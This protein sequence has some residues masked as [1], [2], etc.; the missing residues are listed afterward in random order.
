MIWKS[1]IDKQ[2]RKQG[3]K[4][5]PGLDD[6][7]ISLES[8]MLAGRFK[9]QPKAAVRQHCYNFPSNSVLDTLGDKET[10]EPIHS[11]NVVTSK[12]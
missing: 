6:S 3:R 8:G 1:N 5:S 2:L 4:Q 9:F 11:S 7:S 10:L 12:V